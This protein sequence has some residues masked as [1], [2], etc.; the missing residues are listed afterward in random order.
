MEHV[1]I[2]TNV[3]T[4]LLELDAEK[5]PISTENF[6]GY[7]NDDFY[8]GTIFHRVIDG[9]MIQGGGLTEDMKQKTTKSPIKNEWKNGL[10]NK[11]GTIAMARTSAPDSATSQF[12]INVKDNA[13]LDDARGGAAYAVFGKV[14]GGM[15]VVDAIR[16]V[17]TARGDVPVETITILSASHLSDSD[18]KNLLM[19]LDEQNAT[20]LDTWQDVA[21]GR[22]EAS[23]ATLAE[24]NQE[25]IELA[26][27]FIEGRGIDID[28]A[29]KTESGLWVFDERVGKENEIQAGERVRCHYDLWLPN[30]K[31]LQSSRSGG[32]T[33]TFSLMQVVAAWKEGIPGMKEGGIRWLISPPDLAYGAA[34]RPGIPK[35]AT[36]VFKIGRAHV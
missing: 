30:G 3:G 32:E 7:V 11:R 33:V 12:F 27:R 31:A 19:T 5:A 6:L 36:L 22:K 2:K 1:A 17:E 10:K 28:G 24:K 26:E 34:G 21:K 9:F 29:F 8:E 35:D 15:D 20:S 13:N 16:V 4:I 14:I 23:L 25:Q 18:A